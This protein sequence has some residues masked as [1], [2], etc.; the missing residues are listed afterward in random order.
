[1]APHDNYEELQFNQLTPA[2]GEKLSLSVTQGELSNQIS[3]IPCVWEP[4]SFNRF[5]KLC[6]EVFRG[7]FCVRYQSCSKKCQCF[8][9]I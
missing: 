3:D 5:K 6:A 4:V 2:L 8:T 7:F 1:M 9:A